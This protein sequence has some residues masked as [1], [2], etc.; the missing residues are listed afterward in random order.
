MTQNIK[1]LP[2]N[3]VAILL[4]KIAEDYVV[5]SEVGLCPDKK[6][7]RFASRDEDVLVTLKPR[8]K[9]LSMINSRKYELERFAFDTRRIKQEHEIIPRRNL[10]FWHR[11]D[12]FITGETQE[13]IDIFIKLNSVLQDIKDEF[14]TRPDWHDSYSRVLSDAIERVLRIKEADNE[15]DSAQLAYLEQLLDTRY[16][17]GMDD[18]RKK[19][20]SSLR[21]IILRKDENLL[22]R[23]VIYDDY[24]DKFE[25]LESKL[26]N[27]INNSVS[28]HGDMQTNGN[29]SAPNVVNVYPG[30]T[31][32]PKASSSSSDGLNA[33]LGNLF[34]AGLRRDGE[35]QV[36]RTIVITIKDNVV[37]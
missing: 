31:A 35:K 21:D 25:K 22:K 9:A 8:I 36:E 11:Q 6:I 10:Q 18:I 32:E 20:A 24:K 13:K 29:G 19:S 3:A 12:E 5:F 16:R 34:G 37:S 15:I 1:L 23:G 2:L 4:E 30:T 26:M 7:Y 33:V 14:K 27:A 28:K 17:L